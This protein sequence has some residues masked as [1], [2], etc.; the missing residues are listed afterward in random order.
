MHSLSR[1]AVRVTIDEV[2]GGCIRSAFLGKHALMHVAPDQG[3]D[4]LQG[5]CFACTPYFGRVYAPI[6]RGGIAHPLKPTH[7]EASPEI[8]LH[9]EG[10]V[11]GWSVHEQM[12]RALTLETKSAGQKPGHFPFAWSARQSI[13]LLEDG[14]SISLTVTNDDDTPAPMGA[15]L[16]P[17]LPYRADK[18]IAFRYERSIMP[19]GL[20]LKPL[21][22]DL[23]SSPMHAPDELLDHSFA[24]AP[25]SAADPTTVI[26]TDTAST[27]ILETTAPYLHLYHPPGAPFICVEPISHLPGAID[28]VTRETLLAPGQSVSVSFTLRMAQPTTP[29]VLPSV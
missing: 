26:L 27:L 5:G 17:Y 6:V 22:Q 15:G 18:K 23:F 11:Q 7:Q 16:H 4:P 8:A 2:N 9:G 29:G 19:P 14:L 13:A 28:T 12:T 21:A 20:T 1:G 3:T 25:S 24:C 10:W